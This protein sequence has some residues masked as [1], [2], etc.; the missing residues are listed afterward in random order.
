MWGYVG[1][2]ALTA[3]HDLTNPLRRAPIRQRT[4]K[5]ILR[6]TTA[7]LVAQEQTVR[8]SRNACRQVMRELPPL[9]ATPV[10]VVD[11]EQEKHETNGSVAAAVSVALPC[12]SSWARGKRGT[13][14]G[15]Y[16]SRVSSK[17]KQKT[18]TSSIVIHVG[19]AG[20]PSSRPPGPIKGSG[21]VEKSALG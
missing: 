4:L 11:V 20:R 2:E 12:R 6:V 15:S 10:G 14:G 19:A 18:T 1:V 13:T 7:A 5:S 17:L 8:R 3:L 9:R 16:I 21:S